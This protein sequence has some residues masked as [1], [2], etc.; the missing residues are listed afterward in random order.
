MSPE[1][2]EGNEEFVGVSS[3]LHLN[4]FSRATSGLAA[5]LGNLVPWFHWAADILVR[6]GAGWVARKI[7]FIVFRVQRFYL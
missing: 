2:A 6:A 7:T 3:F 1:S 4:S 5:A